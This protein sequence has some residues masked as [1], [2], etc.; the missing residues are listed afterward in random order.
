MPRAVQRF[1]PAAI[2]VAVW[3]LFVAYA[4]PG[5]MTWDSVNQLFQARSGHY[6]NWHPPIM[7]RLWS[8]LDAIVA[9]PALMLVLQTSLFV[10]G[11]YGLIRRYAAPR[12]AAVACA[13]VF[14]FPPVFAP[15]S[16]IW[17]DSLMA[18]MFLCAVAGLA[19][20]ARI[21]RLFA[22]LAFVVV[23][24][25]RYNA[26]I[27][28]V[29]IT[30]MIG[31]YGSGWW[32]ASP[33]GSIGRRRALGAGL[34]IAVS[35]M[36]MLAS[37]ALTRVDEHPF[38]NMLAMPDLAA[39]IA[40]DGP[41]SDGEVRELVAGVHLVVDSNI[42]GTLRSLDATDADYLSL[43]V[44]DQRVF[45]LVTTDVQA[46]AMAHA[47]QR[48]IVEH[49]GTYLAHRFR[50]LLHVL[51]WNQVRILPYV[52]PLT[53][54]PELLAHVGETRSYSRFQL[55][56]AR[57]LGKISRTIMFW[58]MLYFVLGIG[59]LAILWRDPLQRGLL[60]GALG[61][62]LALMFLSPGWEYRYSH[63]MITSVVIATVVR[64]LGVERAARPEALPQAN[65][66]P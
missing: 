56:V 66:V 48:A 22:W 37:R 51:G 41:M 49:P 26:P 29:P 27:L 39:V 64:F 15:M 53:E 46:S 60:I 44:G 7:A 5:L 19:S 43:A 4:W 25:L 50:R 23:A 21:P 58:P 14:L 31:P 1:M 42:Q 20:A 62:E 2:L 30:T 35:L 9:G 8:V 63:W 54:D 47:W 3:G 65:P 6:G 16:T 33:V 40:S 12:R 34:G 17:K 52:T 24:A 38:S 45:D 36:G 57:W 13:I 10:V 18:A 11:L 28:I 32:G 61:Y 55:G 59:L